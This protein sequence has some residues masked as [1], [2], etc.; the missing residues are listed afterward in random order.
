[1]RIYIPLILLITGCS[2]SS[3]RALFDSKA[4]QEKPKGIGDFH[5]LDILK[6]HLSGEVWFTENTDCIKVQ[7]ESDVI[8]D[9]NGSIHLKWDKQEGG[10]DWIGMGIGWDGWSGK[11]LSTIL[12]K[13]A[14]EIKAKTPSGKINSLPLAASLE[15]YGGKA[16]WLG[17]SPEYISY[18]P[19][20][21]WATV[22]LPL[23]KFSWSEFDADAG[24]IKQFMIQFEAAGELYI[25]AIKVV[26][27]DGI[28]EKKYIA[29]FVREAK[30]NI[31]GDLSDWKDLGTASLD[32]A[33]IMVTTDKDALYFGGHVNDASFGDDGDGVE[34]SFS[35]NYKAE[36]GRSQPLM[37]DRHF[38]L[39]TSDPSVL[40]DKRWNNK[41]VT[42]ATQNIQKVKGGYT[43]EIRIPLSYLELPGWVL[44]HEYRMEL[45][46]NRKGS[47]QARWNSQG[48]KGY[49]SNISHWG[50][51]IFT[52]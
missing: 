43:F 9:G 17:M 7:N 1:M 8:Y 28:G 24:N 20:E 38:V 25:D 18:K 19:G 22:T 31:D 33:A 35:T 51:L 47:E 3:K 10:C 30:I 40:L 23:S 26:P 27:Y 44:D 37:S 13:A 16:A 48:L 32:G 34:I 2:L 39:N 52:E 45:A 11:N 5:A 41:R 12:R 36:A 6:D 49:E 15:D 4:D 42:P 50:S 14:I 21:D 46:I 29:S